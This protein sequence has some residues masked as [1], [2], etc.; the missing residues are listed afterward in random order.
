MNATQTPAASTETF[1]P[2]IGETWETSYVT[3]AGVDVAGRKI[4]VGAREELVNGMWSEVV[5][6]R[7][8][9]EPK[10]QRNPW[11]SRAMRKIVP[12][13]VLRFTHIAIVR[14]VA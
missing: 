9:A 10:V 12:S 8:L 7:M 11:T 14:R 13:K 1:V 5:E 6:L 2:A 4:V 3:A